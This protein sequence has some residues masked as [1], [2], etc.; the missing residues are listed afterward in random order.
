MDNCNNYS[1]N[2]LLMREELEVAYFEI[3]HVANHYKKSECL[4]V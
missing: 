4:C 2:S 1:S 3:L